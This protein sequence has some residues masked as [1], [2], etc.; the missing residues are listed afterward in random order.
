METDTASVPDCP[1]LHTMATCH[2]LALI[3]GELKGDP[4]DLK[5][6]KATGW[7]SNGPHSNPC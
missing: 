1:F 6:F 3:N 7:V 2:S 5:M 4:M